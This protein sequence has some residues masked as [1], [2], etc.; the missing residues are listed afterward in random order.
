M[1]RRSLDGLDR[2]WGLFVATSQEKER[3]C[4]KD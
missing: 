1:D 4:N 2:G 3:C